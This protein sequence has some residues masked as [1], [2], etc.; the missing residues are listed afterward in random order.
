[1]AT[2]KT[3]T[4]TDPAGNDVLVSHPAD[5]NNLVYGQGYKVK[6]S[7]TP[8]QAIASLIEKNED[9]LIA[10]S[11]QGAPAGTAPAK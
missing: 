7:Q 10:S 4:L 2:P 5:V 1:M 11:P 6:G 3:V 8:D 9:V